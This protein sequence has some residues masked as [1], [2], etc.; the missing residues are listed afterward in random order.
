MVG[1]GGV[2]QRDA[3]KSEPYRVVLKLTYSKN[4]SNFGILASGVLESLDD[5]HCVS[6]FDPISILGMRDHDDEYEFP[7]IDSYR[8]SDTW[9]GNDDDGE[10]SL[11]LSSKWEFAL[12]SVNQLLPLNWNIGVIAPMPVVVLFLRQIRCV[13]K[14]KMQILLAF[15]NSST[16]GSR[17]VPFPFD[18][19]T[20]LIAEGAWDKEENRLYGVACRILNFT[21]STADAFVGDRSTKFSLGFRKILSS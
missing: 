6:N 20:T 15:R 4:S 9:S 16:F 10:E 3:G 11:P 14:G 5:K 8:H 19:N 17:M 1:S 12:L 7:L 13:D 2:S 18:P 21:R